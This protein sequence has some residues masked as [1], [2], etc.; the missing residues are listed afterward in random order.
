M[1]V[2]YSAT[3]TPSLPNNGVVT[4]TYTDTSTGIG[5][6]TSRTLNIYDSNG[7]LL[8]TINMGT[9]PVA[10]YDISS[11]LYL[12]FRETIVDNTGTYSGE[13]D[14]L[15]TVFYNV[16]FVN[17]LAQ[18]DCNCNCGNE[19][20]NYTDIADLYLS[21]AEASALLS[22]PVSAQAYI[23]AANYFITGNS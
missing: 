6:I 1:A 3:V 21:G 18:L 2:V 22:N 5:T 20:L 16:S 12:S 15:S 23:T 13:V 19:Q 10:T 11:D 7:D 17:V 4:L 8:Q 9:N 14:Y